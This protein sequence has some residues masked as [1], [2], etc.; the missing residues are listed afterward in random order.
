LIFAFCLLPFAFNL[1]AC[2]KV[3]DPLPPIPRAPM[4]ISELAVEQQG[5]RL[6][7]SFPLVRAPRAERLQRIDIYRLI[8]PASAPRGLTEED[9]AA[10]S[11]IISSITAD[12]LPATSAT[13]TYGD[14]LDL[15]SVPANTRYRYAVR[16]VNQSGQPADF[17]NYAQITPLVAV[18][19]PPSELRIRLSQTELELT[20]TP[21]AANENGTQPANVSSYNIYRRAGGRLTKLNAQPAREPHF[22]DRT[23]QFGAQYEYHVRS[24]SLPSSGAS[25]TEAIESNESAHIAITPQD[26][27]PPSAPASITIASI[28]GVV[29]LFWPLN[30][31]PDVAGYNIYRSEDEKAPAAAWVKLNA[32]LHTTGSFRDERVQIGKRYFY[33][34]TAVDTA[35]NE[36]ARSATESEVV[37]P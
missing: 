5:N 17:S 23:F 32:R 21:P 13:I 31:E 2:G 10:R 33:Q 36:S 24:L 20:W 22:A 30:P 15:K 3:G 26:T 18:A 27:F 37:N 1:A 6:M 4:V 35:G 12:Q 34:L 14:A 25:L 28:N 8:E 7:L 9:F 11:T 29:S 16:L 19:A